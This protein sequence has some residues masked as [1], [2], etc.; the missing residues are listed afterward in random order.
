[1]RL[2]WMLVREYQSGQLLCLVS[3]FIGVSVN[4]LSEIWNGCSDRYQERSS[5]NYSE[6]DDET[7]LQLCQL[8]DLPSHLHFFS[9]F[10]DAYILPFRLRVFAPAHNCC[11]G[12]I[13]T[14]GLIHMPLSYAYCLQIYDSNYGVFWFDL[15]VILF[16]AP[17]VPLLA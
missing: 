3:W 8:L 10:T 13:E 7:E 1:M 15:P 4:I 14:S 12:G 11:P 17:S 9:F 16:H 2:F 5:P 6:I